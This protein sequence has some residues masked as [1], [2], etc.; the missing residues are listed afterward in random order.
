MQAASGV[1]LQVPMQ[2]ARRA[3]TLTQRLLAFSRRQ[4]LD[5]KPID[6]NKL[7]AE[8][9]EL[10]RRTLGEVVMLETVLAGGLWRTQADPNQLE[11]AILNLAVN[12]RDAMPNGG[13][14]TIETANARLDDAYVAALAEPLPAGQYVQIAVS[15]T[16]QGWTRPRWRGCSSPS[17]PPRRPGKGLGWAEP[18]LWVCA[19]VQRPCADL[20]RAR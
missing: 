14:L 15:D 3:A 20:Q 6:A 1:R 12:A 8:M 4:P 18:S 5:P 13:K 16:A 11:N 10:L 9:S 17:S 19:P 2:G 7:V